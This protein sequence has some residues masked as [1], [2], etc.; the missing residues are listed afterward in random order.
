VIRRIAL[1]LLLILP[2]TVTSQIPRLPGARPGTPQPQRQQR[3]T[4]NDS[5]RVKWPA[6]DTV[7]QRL[8]SKQGYSITRYLGDTAYFDANKRVLDLLAATKRPAVVDRDSQTV[9]S[10]SGIY[11][12]E[13]IRHGV[14]GGHYVL[15]PP[16]LPDPFLLC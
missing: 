12:T 9:V 4:L 6:P 3:D 15:T 7:M 13:S 16:P 2:A 5:T 10:D 14:A 11:Y 1:L 8:L